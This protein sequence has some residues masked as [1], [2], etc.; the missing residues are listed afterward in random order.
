MLFRS[1]KLFAFYNLELLDIIMCVNIV[2][3]LNIA[4]A[5]KE[6]RPAHITII[7][8]VDTNVLDSR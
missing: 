3:I 2:T 8:P 4:G 7:F 1:I 5:D 6:L